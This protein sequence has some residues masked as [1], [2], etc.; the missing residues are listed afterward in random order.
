MTE[1]ME[2]CVEALNL[3]H[4]EGYGGKSPEAAARLLA[5]YEEIFAADERP[6]L[7]GKA[8][9]SSLIW[10]NKLLELFQAADMTVEEQWSYVQQV[11]DSIMFNHLVLAIIEQLAAAERMNECLFYIEQLK[12]V[13]IIKEEDNRYK[14]YRVLLR[15]AAERADA[16]EFFRLLT[17]S[18]P[19]KQRH[20][21]DSCKATLIEKT[22]SSRGV[23]AAL[24]LCGH[25]KIGEKYVKEALLYLADYATYDEMKR[26]FAERPELDVQKWYV[27]LNVLTATYCANVKRNEA[28]SGELFDELFAMADSVDP[29]IKWGDGRLR[30]GLLTQIGLATRKSAEVERCRKAIKNNSM[31]KELKWRLGEW[32]KLN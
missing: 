29:A 9:E 3:C 15:Y 22:C 30:D 14:G 11:A 32:G 16:A 17:L 13:R 18:E 28:G 5:L 27:R 8:D 19:A 23:D 12:A 1:H 31:K 4:K 6:L 10:K 7:F 24:E 2:G 26:L 25:R 21:I 20:E